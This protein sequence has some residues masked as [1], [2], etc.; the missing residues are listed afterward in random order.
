MTAQQQP[1]YKPGDVANGHR[2]DESGTWQ[3]LIGTMP[4]PKKKHTTRNVLLVLGVLV[5]LAFAG[6]VALVGD[7]V[8]EASK[9]DVPG[10]VSQGLGAN[11]ATADVVLGQAVR[12]ESTFWITYLPVT[13]TNSS[14]KRSDYYVEIAANA[15]NGDRIELSNV[16]VLSLDPGQSASSEKAMF[17]EELPAGVTFEV[18]QVQRTASV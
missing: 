6:C 8:N 3:P 13:V 12:D 1:Q 16:L 10:S 7:A 18:I 14:A 2:L 17:V 15:A 5:L 9:P 4:A 11:D